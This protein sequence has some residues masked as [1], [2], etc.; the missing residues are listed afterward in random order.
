MAITA[1]HASVKPCYRGRL[2]V[3]R[4]I[5]S[6]LNTFIHF[7]VGLDVEGDVV[8]EEEVVAAWFPTMAV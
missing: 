8:V 5:F 4:N 7:P 1:L 6:S 2:H 3:I